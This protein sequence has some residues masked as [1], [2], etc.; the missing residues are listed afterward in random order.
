MGDEYGIRHAVS[1]AKRFR[2]EDIEEFNVN[3]PGE[4]LRPNTAGGDLM[5]Q[6]EKKH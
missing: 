5:H 2:K 3:Q 4:T 1:G 6:R